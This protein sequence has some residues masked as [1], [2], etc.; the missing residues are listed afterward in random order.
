MVSNFLALPNAACRSS[1]FISYAAFV[2]LLFL[3][4][5]FGWLEGWTRRSDMRWPLWLAV[6]LWVVFTVVISTPPLADYFGMVRARPDLLVGIWAAVFVWGWL[7]RT[8]WRYRV[9]ERI[10]TV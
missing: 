4:P 8:V 9:M 7:L 6:G 2:L 3:E 5:P 1:S 10:L